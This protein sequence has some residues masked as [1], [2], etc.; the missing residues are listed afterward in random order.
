MEPFNRNN[1]KTTRDLAYTAAERFGD[2]PFMRWYE[3]NL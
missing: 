2:E 3:K 1:I